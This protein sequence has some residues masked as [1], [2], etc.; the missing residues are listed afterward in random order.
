M[1]TIQHPNCF[2]SFYVK[3]VGEGKQRKVCL[4][5]VM[6]KMLHVIHAVWTRGTPFVPE[7]THEK[8]DFKSRAS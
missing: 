7:T 1:V 8:C 3:K 2:Q 6:R 5:A 4:C